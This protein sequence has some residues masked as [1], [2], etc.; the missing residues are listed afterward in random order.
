MTRPT[1]TTPTFLWGRR[2]ITTPLRCLDTLAQLVRVLRTKDIHKR[3]RDMGC[4]VIYCSVCI[5]LQGIQW[6]TT[7]VVLS[8]LMTRTPAV[9]L[10]S[11]LRNTWEAGG[12]RTAT[13]PI[14]MVSMQPS[15]RTRYKPKILI[16]ICLIQCF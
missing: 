6:D 7:M 13:K 11:V 2:W 9:M 1:L 3:V 8:Q 4:S 14:S 15:P 5:C 12:T 10:S 16:Y